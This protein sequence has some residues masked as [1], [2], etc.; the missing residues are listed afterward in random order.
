[1]YVISDLK[2]EEIVGKFYGK[3]NQKEFIVEQVIKTKANKI[4]IKWKDWD[5][6]FNSWV[7]RKDSIN[8]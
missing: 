5:S 2:G 7:D 1:M 4:Y 3:T 6:S 8:E